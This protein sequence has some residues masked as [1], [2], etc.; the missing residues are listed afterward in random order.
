MDAIHIADVLD[1]LCDN[2][3]AAGLGEVGNAFNQ[4]I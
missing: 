4:G 1:D 3:G 2:L